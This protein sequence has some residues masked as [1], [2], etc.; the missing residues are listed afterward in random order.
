MV[1][2]G[3]MVKPG[4]SQRRWPG[5][6]GEASPGPG[7]EADDGHLVVSVE[8]GSRFD[9]EASAGQLHPDNVLKVIPED[10]NVVYV[11][12]GGLPDVG[13]TEDS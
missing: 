1:K 13:G 4:P 3:E 6:T 12:K 5:S 7:A 9:L 10:L 11:P 2:M 8:E